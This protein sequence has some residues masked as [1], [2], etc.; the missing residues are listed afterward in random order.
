MA[1]LAQ[2]IVGNVCDGLQHAS[3]AGF[4]VALVL[5]VEGE[6]IGGT[7]VGMGPSELH[8]LGGPSDGVAQ[9][10]ERVGAEPVQASELARH[11]FVGV[12]LTGFGEARENLRAALGDGRVHEV[13]PH[14]A[15]ADLDRVG[16]QPLATVQVPAA[17]Q[18]ELPVVPV[19]GEDAPLVEAALAQR[20]AL[21]R[22]TVVAGEHAVR[23][24]KQRDLPP[25]LAE[26]ETAL[27]LEGLERCRPGPG[28]SGHGVSSRR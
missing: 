24:V 19:A 22:A 20:I 6:P 12:V 25:R 27:V 9:R 10:I 17:S 15:V 26:H 11:A 16:A 13:D 21:V 5:V 7:G 2:H 28:A 23:G 4:V 14:L 8:A 1:R 18:V 3:E